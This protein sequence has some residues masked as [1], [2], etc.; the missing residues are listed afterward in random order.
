MDNGVLGLQARGIVRVRVRIWFRVRVRVRVRV[1]I[2]FK[3]R[4]S[5]R[6]GMS[7]DLLVTLIF[8][9]CS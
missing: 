5:V 1:R 4:V 3:V 8:K 9:S 6:V 2:W 7:F